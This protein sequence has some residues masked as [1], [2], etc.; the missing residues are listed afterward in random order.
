VKPTEERRALAQLKHARRDLD[1]LDALLGDLLSCDGEAVEHRAFASDLPDPVHSA[2]TLICERL[3]RI[4]ADALDA[5]NA[6][7]RVE[8]R[9]APG[10]GGRAVPS[11][12]AC[13]KP[14]SRSFC[15][16]CYE[17]WRRKRRAGVGR[18]EFITWRRAR[19]DRRTD[20][21]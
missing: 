2:A 7:Q 10:E 11:C 13:G 21:S 5:L 20:A 4:A 19:L 6:A 17:S 9:T 3:D 12:D 16:R 1:R 15:P 18:D 14:T 8:R